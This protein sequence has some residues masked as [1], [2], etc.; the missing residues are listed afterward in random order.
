[1]ADGTQSVVENGLKQINLSGQVAKGFN[2]VIK[3]IL[4]GRA[5]IVFLASDADK[6][7]KD[8][9]VGLAKKYNVR[10]DEN[11]KKETLGDV[12]GQASIKSGGE[13]R[14]HI[15][16]GACAITKYGPRTPATDEFVALFEGEV[17]ADE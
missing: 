13:V 7:Y 16:C 8:L 12:L 5:K 9:I 6:N 2:C 14:K 4:K 11:L 10:L 1:M 3:A 15:A 17:P